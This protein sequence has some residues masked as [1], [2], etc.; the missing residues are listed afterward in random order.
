[1]T[2]KNIYIS[3]ECLL[4]NNRKG[5]KNMGFLQCSLSST[6]DYK[7]KKT[8]KKQKSGVFFREDRTFFIRRK[9]QNQVRQPNNELE[10]K[11]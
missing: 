5:K 7:K 11:I 8:K 9:V 1:M 6:T 4:F 3:W 2:G 10:T